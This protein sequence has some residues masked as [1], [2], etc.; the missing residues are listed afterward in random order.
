MIGKIGVL[1]NSDRN[2][3]AI[4]GVVKAAVESGNQVSIFM[5]DDGTLLAKD[6]CDKLCD[7]AELTFCDHSAKPRGVE[8]VEGVAASSQFQNAVMMHEADRVV[9]F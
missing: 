2:L 6:L 5:M 8:G 7:I 3:D 1:V 4:V 9:V